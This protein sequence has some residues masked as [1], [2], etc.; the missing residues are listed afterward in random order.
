MK[1]VVNSNKNNAMAKPLLTGSTLFE[2]KSFHESIKEY[3]PTP[4][5]KLKKMADT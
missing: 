3:E 2:A 4:L 1:W 5:V